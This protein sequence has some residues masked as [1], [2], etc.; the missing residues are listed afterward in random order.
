ML[1]RGYRALARRPFLA[2]VFA[3]GLGL[4]V[5]GLF[6]GIVA[7]DGA[8]YGAMAESLL[9]HGEFIM[10][11][12]E[13][14]SS[15]WLPTLSH[16]YSPGYPAFLTPFVAVGGLTPWSL[17]L[18]SFVSGLLLLAVVYATTR[19]LY[20]ADK[21]VLVTAA[22]AADPVLI[23]TSSIGYS[24]GFLTL[25]FVLT[26]WAI[27]KSLKDSRY[28][29]LAGIFAGAAYLTKGVLGWFFLVAGLAGLAWRFHFMRW[30]VFKDRY[31]LAAIG[32]F[33]SFVAFWAVRNLVHFWDGSAAGLLDA[34]QSSAYFSLATQAA[35]AHP[36]DLAFILV[37]RIPLYVAFFLLIGLFWLRD[38]RRMPKL[39][40]EHY[41]G[42]W[43]AV[44]LT[45]V[46]A[47]IV[48]GILWTLE[49]TPIFW[50]D[51]IRYVVLANPILLWL[52]V[53]DAK[54]ETPTFRRKYAAMAVVLLVIAVVLVSAPAPGVDQ[55]FHILREHAPPGSVIAIDGPA[56]YAVALYV[57]GD[58]TYVK[59]T[60][61]VAADFIITDNMTATFP[62]YVL[63]GRGLTTAY[64]PGFVPQDDAAVWQ[65]A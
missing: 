7:A 9:Q 55:A 46:L 3:V 6:T 63:V 5:Y 44:G 36:L 47:W 59:Y 29:V 18:G 1:S 28:M 56:R 13:S 65:H 8:A 48:A 50:L 31:Y 25:L 17:E 52:V 45:Y 53:K 61:G 37:A 19:D 15:S 60:P 26:L 64:I 42:L 21:A 2:L 11:L 16:H 35:V 39:S 43:L 51:Q 30:R 40:D 49:R 33:G 58:R 54:I 12:G 57:G 4:R 32:I 22:A 14:F 24:E 34:W 62:G 38:F 20:G 10:P 27:L 41:S 23:L